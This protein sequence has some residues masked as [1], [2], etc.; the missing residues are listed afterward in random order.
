M[1]NKWKKAVSALTLAAA[2][3]SFAVAAPKLRATC[4]RCEL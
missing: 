3:F 2:A 1:S 4:P